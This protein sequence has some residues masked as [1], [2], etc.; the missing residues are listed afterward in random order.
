MRKKLRT[1]ISC[2]G[3]KQYVDKLTRI[4]KDS[5]TL[6]DLVFA[7]SKVKCKVHGE[8]KITDHEWISVE[9]N[10]I[11]K[12]GDKYREFSSRDY[13]KFHIGDFF[14]ALEERIEH[15]DELDV[16]VR[17]EKFIQNIVNALD[18]VAPKEKFK[19]PKILEGNKWYTDEIRVLAKK[20]DEACIRAMYT[21][22]EQDWIQFKVERNAVVTLII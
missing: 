6:I 21:G 17:A 10:I 20:R 14:K 8:P 19:I 4:T 11:N 9:I 5:K 13:S 3:M 16:N 12:E 15:I 18:I 1:K 7:N 22:N 2:L